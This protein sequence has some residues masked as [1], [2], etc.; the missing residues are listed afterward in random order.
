[1]LLWHVLQRIIKAAF[2]N[3]RYVQKLRGRETDT[4][5]EVAVAQLTDHVASAVTAIETRPGAA[6]ATRDVD[7]C[8]HALE[9]LVATAASLTGGP[10]VHVAEFAPTL[11]RIP[12]A[13]QLPVPGNGHGVA[14]CL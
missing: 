6:S 9:A 7:D 13:A 10:Q 11:L 8:V 3:M 2:N 14:W 5:H 12:P 1:M 4:P